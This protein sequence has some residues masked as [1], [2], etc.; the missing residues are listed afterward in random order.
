MHFAE[1]KLP[2]TN[3]ESSYKHTIKIPRFGGFPTKLAS[4]KAS[5]FIQCVTQT[6]IFGNLYYHLF[7]LIFLALGDKYKAYHCEIQIGGL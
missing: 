7:S 3:W 6:D 5:L 4:Y 1:K 2:P